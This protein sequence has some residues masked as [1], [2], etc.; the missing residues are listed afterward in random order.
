MPYYRQLKAADKILMFSNY[1]HPVISQLTFISETKN[2][3]SE[4]NTAGIIDERE[5]SNN[6]IIEEG[7]L[8]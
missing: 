3:I 7:A 2:P 5:K 1:C 6:I 4:K 8:L